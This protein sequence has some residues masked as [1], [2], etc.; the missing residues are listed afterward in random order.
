MY[1]V[2]TKLQIAIFTIV[3][4]CP[5]VV[6]GQGLSARVSRVNVS[7]KMIPVR[8]V[9]A[10]FDA[11][12]IKVAIAYNKIGATS[13][14][15]SI[16][17]KNGATAAINGTYFDAYTS[18]P[19]KPPYNTLITNGVLRNAAGFGTT[20]GFDSFGNYMLDRVKWSIRNGPRNTNTPEFWL[21]AKE[22]MGCG[23]T[24][25]KDGDICLNVR[26]EGFKDPRIVRASALR[27]AVGL[28]A[29]R[30][31][32]F[33]TC[34]GTIKQLAQVM[35]GLGAI[36]A[37][38]LDGGESS[39]MWCRG[40]YVTGPG[41]NVSNAL[42]LV[43]VT[44]SVRSPLPANAL[45]DLNKYDPNL[46]AQTLSKYPQLRLSYQIMADAI[47][48]KQP[49]R[50]TK[51]WSSSFKWDIESHTPGIRKSR[52][53][54]LD[55]THSMARLSEY[56]Q[57]GISPRWCFR[58]M[59]LKPYDDG[60]QM[61]VLA[62]RSTILP[63]TPFDP[64]TGRSS[65]NVEAVEHIWSMDVESGRWELMYERSRLVD[66]SVLWKYKSFPKGATIGN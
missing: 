15:G 13:S 47:G 1:L 34:T 5:S 57:S 29:N 26:G 48:S 24:L 35:K 49:E 3:I 10:S 59:L 28:T 58:I 8:V 17:S 65:G 64:S 42:L 31:I 66:Q 18:N 37:M 21:S 19:Y 32:I 41:R 30:Q 9:S 40:K 53:D 63:F 62:Y 51:L 46:A 38:N 36:D 27:S 61:A 39:A 11:Y 50:L 54:I 2:K 52:M 14:V 16:A 56:L 44:R 20:L 43:P 60:H 7:G 22:V 55:Y 6:F 23:P 4:L 25:M 45:V 12:R 33:V